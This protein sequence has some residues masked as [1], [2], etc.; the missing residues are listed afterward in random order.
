METFDENI[1]IYNHRYNAATQADTWRRTQIIGVSWYG[2]RKVTASDNGL[3][4]ADTYTVRIPS[5]VLGGFLLPEEYAAMVDVTNK[6]T[7]QS[8]DIVV[9]GL[10]DTEIT[11]VSDLDSIPQKFVAVGCYD[12]RRGLLRHI[13]IEGA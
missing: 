12:N 1:T 5:N 8:G 11:R 13:K 3:V 4:S 2:G 10:V 7:V 6:W 9:K